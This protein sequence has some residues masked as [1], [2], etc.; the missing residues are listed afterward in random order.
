MYQYPGLEPHR[1]TI[2]RL[3]KALKVA[4]AA[5]C[6]QR[7]GEVYRA[8]ARR[9]GHGDVKAF[10]VLLDAIW[11]DTRR[12]QASEQ[13]HAK[14][15]ARGYKLLRQETSEDIYVAGA[16]FAILSL[17]YSNQLLI[18]DQT[19]DVIYSAN[20]PF[21]SIDSFLTYNLT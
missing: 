21:N 18:S 2:D 9:T 6:A 20:Q 7:Q 4:L 10:D 15:L 11:E 5:V 14:W 16:E 17:L 19:Q 3:P 1:A 12:P 8:Y 13:E